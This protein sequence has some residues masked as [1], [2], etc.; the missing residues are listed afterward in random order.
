MTI[1]KA[2]QV[3][4]Y[5]SPGNSI[6]TLK[7]FYIF[8]SII[9][10]EIVV[11]FGPL[12]LK[13]RANASLKITVWYNGLPVFHLACDFK[14]IGWVYLFTP[15]AANLICGSLILHKSNEKSKVV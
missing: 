2:A 10:C 14:W 6:T 4:G 7:A 13:H 12:I 1:H 9:S 15:Y 5:I 3:R 8:G 11:S